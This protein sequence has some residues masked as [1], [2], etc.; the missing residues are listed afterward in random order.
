MKNLLILS[1]FL[2]AVLLFAACTENLDPLSPGSTDGLYALGI[3]A[4]VPLVIGNTWNYNVVVYD[5]SSAERTRYT[6][7][8]SVVDTVKADTTKIPLAS[9]DKAKR[10]RLAW[11]WYIL[12]GEMGVRT[13]WQ[14]DTI[15]NL[16]IRKVQPDSLFLQQTAFD[17]RASVG[18]STPIRYIGADT[19]VWASGDI[20]ITSADSVKSKLVSVGVDSL[21]TTLSSSQYY[22]YRQSYAISTDYTDYYFKP[23]F[24]L[25]L[26]ERFKRKPDGTIVCIRRDQLASY[27]FK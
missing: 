15:E 12:E 1:L 4:L 3:K 7:T 17:F 23:G 9:A 19:S 10:N 11:L 5:T 6:Y 16:R 27:Y 8:L 14:V 24:G 18:D 25:F 22:K 20:V 21:R 26:I 2:I 13:Y